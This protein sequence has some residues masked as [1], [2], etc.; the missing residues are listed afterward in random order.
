MPADR[1]KR[2]LGQKLPASIILPPA[3]SWRFRN[4]CSLQSV[5]VR[6]RRPRPRR[7]DFHLYRDCH[8]NCHRFG[9]GQLFQWHFGQRFGFGQRDR[10]CHQLR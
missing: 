1:I 9:F 5:I 6:L 2:Q 3:R 7:R 4:Q 8:R 10:D